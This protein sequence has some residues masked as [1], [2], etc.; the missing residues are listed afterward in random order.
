MTDQKPVIFPANN[1]Y[2]QESTSR[3][4]CILSFG[5]H[6]KGFITSKPSR[7]TRSRVFS[8]RGSFEHHRKITLPRM[9]VHVRHKSACAATKAS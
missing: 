6:E 1:I 2:K 9:Y 4:N 5:D 7:K 3:I 8:R